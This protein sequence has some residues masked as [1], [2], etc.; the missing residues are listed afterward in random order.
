MSVHESANLP[1]CDIG[2][3]LSN[4][5]DDVTYL[6]GVAALPATTRD[7]VP[8]RFLVMEG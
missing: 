8:A 4:S 2:E 7:T 6:C 5:W 1:Y 3:Y